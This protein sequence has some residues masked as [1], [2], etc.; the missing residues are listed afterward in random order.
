MIFELRV[1]WFRLRIWIS[2]HLF[3]DREKELIGDY[4]ARERWDR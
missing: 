2:R 3:S 4:F 1:W